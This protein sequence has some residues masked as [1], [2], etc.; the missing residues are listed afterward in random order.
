MQDWASRWRLLVRGIEQDWAD[1]ARGDRGDPHMNQQSVAE[2]ADWMSEPNLK[3]L[4][5][6]NL[7]EQYQQHLTD[8]WHLNQ[9]QK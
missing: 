5:I 2:F 9:R 1:L 6:T 4:L 3:I 7:L 8:I